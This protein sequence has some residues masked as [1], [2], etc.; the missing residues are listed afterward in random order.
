MNYARNHLRKRDTTIRCYTCIEL[1]HIAKNC[2]NIG[3]V[4]DEKKAKVD[5]IRKQMRQQCIP[6]P[7]KQTSPSNGS[8]V[9]LEEGGSINSN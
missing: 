3:K 1:G 6:K 9:T 4:E 2:M 7:T 8:Q 5:N